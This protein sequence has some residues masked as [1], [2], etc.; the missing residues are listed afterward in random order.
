VD[1]QVVGGRIRELR[2]QL[3]LKQ[4]ELAKSLEVHQTQIS[5]VEAGNK[6]PS[7]E[8]LIFL[9]DHCN[10][11]IDKILRGEGFIHSGMAL[12][13]NVGMH[14][15][16]AKE[17]IESLNQCAK[18][19]KKLDMTAVLGIQYYENE[20]KK[21]RADPQVERNIRAVRMEGSVAN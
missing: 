4:G 15:T 18:S 21:I 7:F 16:A 10:V 14:T 9:S 6:K 17:A 20:L 12:N 13:Q 5:E 11:S 3:G 8:I 2:E 19:I 1:L